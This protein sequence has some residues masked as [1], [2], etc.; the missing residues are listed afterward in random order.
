MRTISV[1]ASP[2]GSVKVEANGFVGTGCKAIT[3]ALEK[4]LGGT[5]TS[6][7][8]KAELYIVEQQNVQTQTQGW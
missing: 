2:D 3:E 8:D 1:V 7:K 6:A 4:R 5:V